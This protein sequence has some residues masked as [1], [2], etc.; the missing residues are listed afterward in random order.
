MEFSVV[1]PVFN[2]LEFLQGCVDNVIEQRVPALEH[3][4]VDGG[5][6]DG[7][8]EA[9]IRLS[10]IHPHIRV[11]KGP[12]KGQS[13]AM[14]KGMRAAEG[15]VVGVLNVDDFYEPGAVLE[16]LSILLPL[17][18][19]S[20]VAGN[21]KIINLETGRIF[22][23][24]PKKLSLRSF[25]MGSPIP[26]NPSAYFYHKAVHDVVGYYDVEDHFAMDLDFLLS[27]AR[28]VNMIYVD[29][30]WGNFRLGPGCKTFD[31]TGNARKRVQDILKKNSE[32][33]S[34]IENL[35]FTLSRFYGK[36]V[37][38]LSRLISSRLNFQ[39]VR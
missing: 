12:D 37:V 1:T 32:G 35:Y 9:A 4:I 2:G 19:P 22:W 5:S 27:C 14:N 24:K 3:I 20:L 18:M 38:R 29:R 15:K 10:E 17:S 13:D 33:F 30:Y 39:S 8:L 6:T 34:K 36:I 7:T 31:D 21:C 23:S 16:A 25:Q 11:I 26:A 28:R